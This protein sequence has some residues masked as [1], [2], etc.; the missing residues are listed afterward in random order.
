LQSRIFVVVTIVEAKV[1]GLHNK[2]LALSKVA[3][4]T[5]CSVA[6]L[7]PDIIAHL[8]LAFLV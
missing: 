2:F 7:V 5:T 8:Y 6:I 3:R 1:V 4:P